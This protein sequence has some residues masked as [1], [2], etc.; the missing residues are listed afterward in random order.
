MPESRE[1]I[2]VSFNE[3]LGHKQLISFGP[4]LPDPSVDICC[5]GPT[6]IAQSED[7]L[8]KDHLLIEIQAIVTDSSMENHVNKLTLATEVDR[9]EGTNKENHLI[10]ADKEKAMVIIT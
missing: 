9:L 7:P 6:Q 4:K 8:L 1:V 10:Q 3:V 5:K 2:T